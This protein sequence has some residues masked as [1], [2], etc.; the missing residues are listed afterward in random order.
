MH[1]NYGLNHGRG[2]VLGNGIVRARALE[3]SHE[4]QR[5]LFL[6]DGGHGDASIPE[7]VEGPGRARCLIH[8]TD[9]L[10]G[11]ADK[12]LVAG[13]LDFHISASLEV[14][15]IECFLSFTG[16]IAGQANL[17]VRGGDAGAEIQYSDLSVWCGAGALQ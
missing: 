15:A 13:E 16:E 3:F 12:R 2:H 10:F 14:E 4:T 7:Y 5:L 11:I 6:A 9:C 8:A 1:A 17:S